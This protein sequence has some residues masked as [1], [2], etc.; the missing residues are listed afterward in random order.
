MCYKYFFFL[1]LFVLIIPNYL[2]SQNPI[3]VLDN[4]DKLNVKIIRNN[5]EFITNA[6]SVKL[7]RDDY[8]VCK[9]FK[10][11]KFNWAPYTGGTL[12]NDSTMQVIFSPPEKIKG[13]FE[14]ISET[15]VDYFGLVRE[16]FHSSNT[17]VRDFDKI[18]TPDST[19]TALTFFPVK[20][21]GSNG[22]DFSVYDSSGQ[23]V[24]NMKLGAVDFFL[25]NPA[26]YKFNNGES[27]T[28]EIKNTNFSRKGIIKFLDE[29]RCKIIKGNFDIIDKKI[30]NK[31]DRIIKKASYLQVIS[32]IYFNDVDL[33]WLSYQMID[34]PDFD[35]NEAAALLKRKFYYHL[36][37]N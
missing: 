14:K 3:G 31:K 26:E 6:R 32:D 28:W 12:T 4:K 8:I 17:V 5:S 18:E 9:D 23:K 35:N 33:Y 21:T 16:G 30:K 13:F 27:Y 1:S 20:F 19:I 36:S 10:N 34:V 25:L 7:F 22:S 2:Y 11:I 37:M 15:F 29:N 24:C